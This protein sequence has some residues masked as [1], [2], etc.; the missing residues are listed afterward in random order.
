M[1]ARSG[2][3]IFKP[4]VRFKDLES[5]YRE[6]FTL[7]LEESDQTRDDPEFMEIILEENLRDLRKDRKPEGFNREGAMRLIFPISDRVEF[8]VYSRTTGL[9]VPR[10]AEALSQFLWKK[11]LKHELEWDRLV[12]FA[13]EG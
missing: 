4:K 7:F 8:Y 6:L 3:F 2:H 1:R 10:V 13:E 9:D 12:L 5:V 11:G